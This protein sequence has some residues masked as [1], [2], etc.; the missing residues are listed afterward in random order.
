MLANLCQPNSTGFQVLYRQIHTEMNTHGLSWE[1]LRP[2]LK[3]QLSRI[4]SGAK[5]YNF[6]EVETA[7]RQV[8]LEARVPSNTKAFR[9]LVDE[10][11]DIFDSQFDISFFDSALIR[12][13]KWL[14]KIFTIFLFFFISYIVFGTIIDKNST[15]L[16][17]TLISVFF[18]IV[19][20]GIYEGLQI[21][22]AMLRYQDPDNF[23]SKFPRASLLHHD[24]FPAEST[25][26]FLAGRQLFVIVIVFIL[27][28][29]TSFPN[30]ETWP[31]TQ[32]AF[33]RWM[34]PWFNIVF[35]QNGV[36][37]ALFI[38]W[39]GQL[40]PQFLANRFP[41][42]FLNVP[43]MEFFLKL[44]L[45]VDKLGLTHPGKWPLYWMRGEDEKSTSPKEVYQ[46]A[47]TFQ[48]Y[49]ILALKK[50]WNITFDKAVLDYQ[51]TIAVNADGIS[52]VTDNGLMVS[53]N[54][55]LLNWQSSF[56]QKG[57]NA[58]QE[59]H[60]VQANIGEERRGGGW[61]KFKQV[62]YVNHGNFRP[63]DV[64]LSKAN[65]TLAQASQDVIEITTPTKYLSF[66][67]C[68]SNNGL[69]IKNPKVVPYIEEGLIKENDSTTETDD[70]EIQYDSNGFPFCE[71]VV[72]YP[73]LNR[74]YY[75]SWEVIYN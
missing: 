67:I 48:G 1:D 26:R 41:K 63:G 13:L 55:V 58:A 49:S 23:S 16:A 53:G 51:N 34:L 69:R 54:N 12:F 11:S 74:K 64:I 57:K 31:L 62:Y 42:T 68:F 24:F 33:P 9:I 22:I 10:L 3:L 61:R 27:A 29:L 21:S 15:N 72:M 35:I 28:Q 18:L 4:K 71:Y 5:D 30:L 32:I 50:T 45:F 40:A 6:P 19:I 59:R 73:E 44:A 7:A 39:L 65:V 56:I 8:I 70:L 14:R 60:L 37:G 20:L 47:I 75:I 43:F 2:I 66:R 17:I 38:L 25:R 52:G 46:R 36:A